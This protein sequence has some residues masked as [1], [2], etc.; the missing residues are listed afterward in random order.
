MGLSVHTCINVP[1]RG[2]LLISVREDY[3]VH[4]KG[5]RH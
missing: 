4:M 3:V 2:G 1:E 5:S